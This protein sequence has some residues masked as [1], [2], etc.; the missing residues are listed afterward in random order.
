MKFSADPGHGYSKFYDG[1]ELKKLTTVL[2]EPQGDLVGA[3]DREEIETDEGHWYVGDTALTQSITKITGRDEGW[4]FTP[5]YRAMLLFGLSEY[6]SPATDS[7]VVDLVLSLP[8]VDYRNNRPQLTKL[9]KRTHLVKRPNRRNLLASIRNVIWLPQG[10]APAKPYLSLDRTVA[11][12]D[13]GSRNINFATFEGN[14]LIDNKT[15]SRESG[16]TEILLDIGKRVK[17]RTRREF[18]IPQIVKILR[19]KTA[20]ASNKDVDV[21]DIVDERL[22]YYFRFLEALISDIWGNVTAVDN[23]VSFGGGIIL[24]GERLLEKYPDQVVV[25]DDPQFATVLAQYNYLKRKLG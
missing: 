5:E 7:V 8:I 14:K 24:A 10:F 1:S 25:L 16:A 4:A 15:D 11:T 21:S 13:L 2:G 6:V 9:L 12:F 23:L 3:N 18:T 20:R 22:A 19:S 17:D